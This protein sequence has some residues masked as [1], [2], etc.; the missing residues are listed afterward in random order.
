MGE[1]TVPIEYLNGE[2]KDKPGKMEDLY[3]SILDSPKGTQKEKDNPE[4][5]DQNHTIRKNL[6]DH[7][8]SEPQIREPKPYHIH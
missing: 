2:S 4:K 6:V 8:S 1:R 5:M 3:D 7:L